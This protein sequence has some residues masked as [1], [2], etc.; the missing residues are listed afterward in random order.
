MKNDFIKKLDELEDILDESWNLPLASNKYIVNG[1]R[2]KEL[3]SDIKLS[4]PKEMQKAQIVLKTKEELLQNAKREKDAL[5]K[6][7]KREAEMMIQKA[8]QASERMEIAA[9]NQA[10]KILDEQEI[11][12]IAEKRA[13]DIVSKA[14]R[15]SVK[16]KKATREYIESILTEPYNAL[17]KATA[18]IEKIKNNY[19][20]DRE[21]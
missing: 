20:D 21:D 3:I 5:I 12:K 17:K 13:E 6:S 15:E 4:L 10:R 9:K 1:E 19:H 16:M 18:S 8:Q 11:L 14:K 7:A 2:L